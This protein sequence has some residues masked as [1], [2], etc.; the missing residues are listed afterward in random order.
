MDVIR[1]DGGAIITPPCWASA[2]EFL[3]TVKY[4]AGQFRLDRTLGRSTGWS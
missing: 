4:Q 2:E 1:D 3:E